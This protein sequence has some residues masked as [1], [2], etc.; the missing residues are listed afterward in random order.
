MHI[1]LKNIQLTNS[2]LHRPTPEVWRV[3]KLWH[4]AAIFCLSVAWATPAPGNEALQD[5]A[6][7]LASVET[8]IRQQLGKQY[9]LQIKLGYLDNRLRLAACQHTPEA[10]FPPRKHTLGP[11]TVGVRCHRPQW[12]V[13]V[14]VEIRAFTQVAVARRPLAKDTVL[15]EQDVSLSKREISG[16]RRGVF[17]N[18][19]ALLGMVV[20]RPLARGTVLT[21]ASVEP[22]RLVQRGESVTIL[23]G[24]GNML[25][26]VQGEALMDG[27]RGQSIRVKNGRSGQELTAEVID[28]STVRV[29]M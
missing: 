9:E 8:H 2:G 18:K 7:I 25:I 19:Q 22:K 11:T 1:C 20:K 16:F 17:E 29:R 12:D 4:A 24:S 3:T 26:R 6:T 28:T 5:P 23:A 21:P 14:P 13:Y 27:H 15:G 10:F